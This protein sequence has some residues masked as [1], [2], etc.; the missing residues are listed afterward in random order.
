MDDLCHE[1]A[2]F[3]S[4]YKISDILAIG[5]SAIRL[6]GLLSFLL[7]AKLSYTFGK[8]NIESTLIGKDDY[9]DYV[10]SNGGK[11]ANNTSSGNL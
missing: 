7:R 1:L 11:G 8:V 10:V 3:Y 2:E 4:Q 6:G 9:T 5:T